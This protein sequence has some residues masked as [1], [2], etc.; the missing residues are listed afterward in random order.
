MFKNILQFS[1]VMFFTGNICLGESYEEFKQKKFNQQSPVRAPVQFLNH[2]TDKLKTTTDRNEAAALSKQI[3]DLLNEGKGVGGIMKATPNKDHYMRP[4]E[5]KAAY[6]A[7][8]A[9]ERFLNLDVEGDNATSDPRYIEDEFVKRGYIYNPQH[10][11]NEDYRDRRAHHIH[12]AIISIASQEYLWN[13]KST[14]MDL[15]NKVKRVFNQ[16]NIPDWAKAEYKKFPIEKLITD[17]FIRAL[18]SFELPV[19][20]SMK[21][22][23]KQ[24]QGVVTA[25]SYTTAYQDKNN[26]AEAGQTLEFVHYGSSGRG[27]QCGFFSSFLIDDGGE[28][29]ARHKFYQTYTD[30]LDDPLI[31]RHAWKLLNLDALIDDIGSKLGDEAL[32]KQ[33]VSVIKPKAD[34]A[35]VDLNFEYEE[36]KKKRGLPEKFPDDD[37]VTAEQQSLK[38]EANAL[39]SEWK[40]PR[41]DAINEEKI[42]S[43]FNE[44]NH[45]AMKWFKEELQKLIHR[46]FQD[47]HYS[48]ELTIG[49]SE[50]IQHIYDPKDNW[51]FAAALAH[52]YNYNIYAWI[53]KSLFD[54]QYA[55]REVLHNR[56][57]KM[58]TFNGLTPIRTS[59]D[60]RSVLINLIYNSDS[61]KDVHLI[62]TS[63]GHYEKFIRRDDFPAIAR[64]VRHLKKMEMK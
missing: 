2:L 36:E 14:V 51:D 15:R 13:P 6:R 59:N 25:M 46:H 34:Q 5:I 58:V 41:Q 22:M 19:E 10:I 40:L 32:K 26:P 21:E 57:K 18:A 39:L 4:E 60:G 9:T 35:L 7:R 1:I 16:D 49:P 44:N 47:Q 29:T 8:L 37:E 61:A 56:L 38:D 30:H 53:S 11:D 17:N 42:R 27:M 33:Y 20:N 54:S 55:T 62:N 50:V 64:A 23:L 31:Y 24:R 28:N 45:N 12:L 52:I 3:R 48:A 63:G 43:L